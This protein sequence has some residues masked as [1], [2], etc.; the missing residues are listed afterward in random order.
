[1]LKCLD[2]SL[3][4]DYKDQYKVPKSNKKC[5][6]D[7]DFSIAAPKLWN[8]LPQYIKYAHDVKDFKAN[9]KKL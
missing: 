4:S 5:C 2:Y 1:M 6:G 9:L 7:H 8:A 3:Q